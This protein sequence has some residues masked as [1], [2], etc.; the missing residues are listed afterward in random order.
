MISL[1]ASVDVSLLMDYRKYY[2]KASEGV[3]LYNIYPYEDSN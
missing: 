2:S 1:M 3:A